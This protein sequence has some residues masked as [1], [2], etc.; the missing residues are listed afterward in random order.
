MTVT[1]SRTL[2]PGDLRSFVAVTTQRHMTFRSRRKCL[3]AHRCDVVTLARGMLR[4]S[5]SSSGRWAS[6]GENHERR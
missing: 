5:R 6:G 2:W 3:W 4:E 1:P